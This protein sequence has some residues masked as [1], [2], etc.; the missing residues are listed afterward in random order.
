MLESNWVELGTLFAVADTVINLPNMD[1]GCDEDGITRAV[2]S[3]LYERRGKQLTAWMPSFENLIAPLEE[4][5]AKAEAHWQSL[6]DAE[7]EMFKDE[8]RARIGSE[9]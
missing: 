6:L 2:V 4:K 3:A 5:I 9:G 8:V 7:D 1:R